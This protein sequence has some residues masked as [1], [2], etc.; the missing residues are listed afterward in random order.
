MKKCLALIMAM[1]LALAA[2]AC[3]EGVLTVAK[4][5]FHV[6]SSSSSFTGYL[7]VKVENTGDAP[8]KID[9]ASLEIYDA[10]GNSLAST[11]SLWRFAEYLQPGEYTYGYFNPRIEGIETADEVA[12]YAVNI[13]GKE[14][15]NRY[16]FRLPV[17]TTLELGVVEGSM[18]RDYITTTLTNDA[19]QTVYDIVVMRV[20]LDDAGNIL[21][22]DSDNMYS[23]KGLTPGS[24]IVVRRTLATNFKDYFEEKGIVPTQVDTIGYAYGMDQTT[25][26][27][28]GAPA[29]TSAEG[30]PAQAATETYATL[31][32]GSKGDDVKALQQRL[33]DLG[34]LTGS[35]DGNFG[36]G[37]AG[38]V[39]AFQ[40]KAG[41]TANGVADDATQKALFADDAPA[42]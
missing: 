40:Q 11:T 5:S 13:T 28:G 39:S 15:A 26:T 21:Y 3:A 33:K 42:A 35:V 32:K 27:R 4:E 41:L 9:Q 19:D 20:L 25:Y 31:Q 7:F 37:T 16:T 18:N 17:E 29:E 14:L 12:S 1:I 6:I 38:A 36:K 22:L 30:E 8:I 10:E 24:S 2:S 23:Y 34:Y